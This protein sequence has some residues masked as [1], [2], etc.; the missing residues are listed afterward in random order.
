[1]ADQ[2]VCRISI[3]QTIIVLRQ[4]SGN[5]LH[6]LNISLGKINISGERCYSAEFSVLLWAHMEKLAYI[7]CIRDAYY[8]TGPT[9]LISLVF[10]YL[11]IYFKNR[12]IVS[13]Q[14]NKIY[15]T[16]LIK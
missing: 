12:V 6:G 13:V 11:N 1:M 4:D 15:N 7:Y 10:W 2:I 8:D 3:G 9:S 14:P 5:L 16:R